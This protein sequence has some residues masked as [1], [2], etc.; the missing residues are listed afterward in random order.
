MA[1]D[2]TNCGHDCSNCNENCAER[3][4][5]SFLV[6]LNEFSRVGKVIAVGRKAKDLADAANGEWY[7][8]V[9]EALPEIREAFAPGTAL[10]VK[11]SHSMHFERITEALTKDK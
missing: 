7:A 4:P 2:S 3:D 9:D 1:I 6:D 8:T 5:S 11:A 10:L